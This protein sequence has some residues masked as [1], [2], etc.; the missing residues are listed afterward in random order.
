MKAALIDTGPLYSFFD[1]SDKHAKRTREFLRDYTGRLITTLA[2]VTEVSYLLGDIKP[3]Q[4]DFIEWVQKGA[5]EIADVKSQDFSEI[6]KGMKKYAD[7][8]MDF[9][10]ATLVFI[11]N[12]LKVSNIITFDDDFRVYR[13][14]GGS[15]FAYLL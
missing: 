14:A 15:K 9:A 7:T 11:A 12:S 4:L 2:I 6:H 10:D 3:A 1:S 13:L 5:I 8:P